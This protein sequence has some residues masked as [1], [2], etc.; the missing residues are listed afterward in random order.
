MKEFEENLWA[1]A[2]P[3]YETILKSPFIQELGTGSLSKEKFL[4]YMEQ[5]KFF[6]DEYTKIL[7]FIG[8]KLPEQSKGFNLFQRLTQVAEAEEDIHHFYL[9]GSQLGD[10]SEPSPTCTFYLKHLGDAAANSSIIV[11]IAAVLPCF[12]IYRE[13]AQQ[14]AK[15]NEV[16]NPFQR[17]IDYYSSVGDFGNKIDELIV[18]LEELWAA[19]DNNQH[20][21][22]I[23]A[24]KLSARLELMFWNSCYQLETWEERTH[25]ISVDTRLTGS[26]LTYENKEKE[27][28]IVWTIA[29]S[30][31]GGGAGIQAD[32]HTFQDLGVYGCSVIT[33]LTAQNS[34]EVRKVQP[35]EPSMITSQLETLKNDLP[36]TSIKIGMLVTGS[37]M[38]LV[39][40]FLKQYKGNFVVDPVMVSTSGDMLIDEDA[41]LTLINRII[42]YAD[43]LTPN[44]N[45][46]KVLVGLSNNDELDIEQAAKTIFE[47]GAKSILIK[48]GHFD[49]KESSDYYYDGKQGRWITS[50]RYRHENTHG[51]GCTLSSALAATIALGYPIL[52]ALIISKSYVTQ[53]IRT[54]KKYGS[55]PGPVTHL[56]WPD[57]TIDFPMLSYQ[58]NYTLSKTPF[59]THNVDGLNGICPIVD[60]SIWVQRMFNAGVKIVQLRVKNTDNALVE[61]EVSKSQQLAV[62]Y[63]AKLIVNDHWQLAIQYGVYGIHLGQADIGQANLKAILAAESRLGISANS[64]SEVA[65][66]QA[67]QPSYIGV[68]PVFFSKNKPSKKPIGLGP[69]FQIVKVSRYPIVA[70]GGITLENVKQLQQIGVRSVAMISAILDSSDPENTIRKFMRKFDS[71]Y[72]IPRSQS[73]QSALIIKSIVEDLNKIRLNKPLIHNITNFVVMQQTANALLALGA[74]P[75]MAHAE[76]E[77]E[78][79]SKIINA[80]VINIGT[81]NANWINSMKIAMQFAKQCNKPIIFDPVGVGATTYRTQ[82]A[83]S[84]LTEINPTVIR[85]NASEIMALADA[86]ASTQGV[87]SIH[88]T[89]Q[90]ISSAKVLANRYN[91]VVVVSGQRDYIV[92]TEK[93][94]FVDNGVAMMAKVTGMGCTATAILAA[95]CAVQDDAFKASQYAMSIMGISGELASKNTSAPGSFQTS[96]TDALSEISAQDI[97]QRLQS[98]TYNANSAAADRWRL[99]SSTTQL[100]KDNLP[101]ETRHI[102]SF[103]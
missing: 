66:A 91:C 68:G 84:L 95:F 90:A 16:A 5:D 101:G 85:G 69:L 70:L 60:S 88:S 53:G 100:T 83:K 54:A 74:S 22:A 7:K 94:I 36:A 63:G 65:I 39:A 52:D 21:I 23:E 61:S 19:A 86:K 67:Y 42:P 3:I 73:T 48:G 1:I 6:V 31:S 43:I 98:G 37:V 20:S 49:T 13:V 92:D 15:S 40:D 44:L 34:T 9:S 32:L 97:G 77:L 18:V 79:L 30:D 10:T 71:A 41:K 58:Q 93:V 80:L 25:P 75:I 51:S 35:V 17:W 72:I 87:D 28:P 26:K 57:N 55:G 45:E 81:L 14:F 89:E 50:P 64:L 102:K 33:A 2:K 4:F 38:V 29:G 96:F 76:E 11:S 24:F 46:T 62:K 99:F 47:M 82:T 59:P 27:R 12:W 56:G 103:S 78:D 8:D